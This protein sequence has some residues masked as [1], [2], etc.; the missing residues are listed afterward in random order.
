MREMDDGSLPSNAQPS[1]TAGDT[2]GGRYV[3]E[4]VLGKG[5]MGVVV[6]A[7]HEPLGHR[8]AMKL[9]SRT[10]AANAEALERFSREARVIASLESDHVVRVTDFGMHAGAPYMVMELL[11]GRDLRAELQ[12]REKLPV[13]E[14]VDY[15]IQAA[16]GLFAAHEKGIVHRDVKLA[17]LFVTTRP[18]GQRSVKVL[19][20]GISKLQSEASEDV[21]LTRTASTLG[22][23]MYMSPEQIRDARKVDA[24]TDVWALGVV[25]YMLMSGRAPFEGQSAN[26]L[27]A[28]ISADA[29]PPLRDIPVPLNAIV[30][31]CLEKS[32]ARRMPA[33]TA[34]ARELQPFASERGREIARQLLARADNDE[35]AAPSTPFFALSPARPLEETAGPSV[36]EAS[37]T[38]RAR[39]S[40][41]LYVAVALGSLVAVGAAFAWFKQSRLTVVERVEVV[42]GAT[43]V[44]APPPSSI[45]SA[46]TP[47]RTPVPVAT[48]VEK[49]KATV[50]HRSAS[51][52]RPKPKEKAFGGSALDGHH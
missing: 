16:D 11:T 19:D 12:L 42:Q 45:A 1:V 49:T 39:P 47:E 32:P 13:A 52:P 7:R 40:R 21:E 26:A 17:N 4:E 36:L 9:M 29:P 3:V 5:G 27:S 6:A 15:V 30:L 8:V 35:S 33:V 31:R 51:K 10:V 2:V 44:V 28:A 46:P 41:S 37:P 43:S 48:V 22:S 20:F 23:P 38:R 24:R 50:V 34:L 25:L 18:D 14:A